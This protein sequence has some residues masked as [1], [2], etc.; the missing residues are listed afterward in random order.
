MNERMNELSK[1]LQE[2]LQNTQTVKK[3]HELLCV[4]SRF[5]NYSANNCIFNCFT[6]SSRF[7]RCWIHKL[8]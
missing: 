8:A 5:Y 2:G 1:M 7:L 4:M 3:Y 6:V